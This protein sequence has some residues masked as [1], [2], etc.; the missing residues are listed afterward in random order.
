MY[1]SHIDPGKSCGAIGY[2]FNKVSYGLTV[3]AYYCPRCSKDFP[4]RNDLKQHVWEKHPTKQPLLFLGGR[5]LSST[6]FTCRNAS[7]LEGL[8]ALNVESVIVNGELVTLRALSAEFLNAKNKFFNI[9]LTNNGITKHFEIDVSIVPDEDIVIIDKIFFDCFGKAL[10]SNK[11]IDIF[12]RLSSRYPAAKDYV[13]GLVSYL[14]ALQAKNGKAGFTAYEQYPSKLA[15]ALATLSDFT[16]PLAVAICDLTLFMTNSLSDISLNGHVAQLIGATNF[17]LN[18]ERMQE[19]KS[20]ASQNIKIP[21]DNASHNINQLINEDSIE[22]L[23]VAELERRA[24]ACAAAFDFSSA[25]KDKVNLILFRK[26]IAE[27]DTLMQKK[28]AKSLKHWD[29]IEKVVVGY[30]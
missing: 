13:D 24:G 16:N 18:G 3:S 10:L 19:T 8:N 27:K 15:Q 9:A 11:S 1:S 12:I 20:P 14:V 21:V 23:S 26:A 6:R 25:D 17:L 4:S 7:M 2:D 22:A 28:Y 30:E 29:E 5:E